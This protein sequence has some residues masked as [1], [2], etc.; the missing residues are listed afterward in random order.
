MAP[1]TL[2]HLL[3]LLCTLSVLS[4]LFS[5]LSLTYA[6]PNFR[7]TP[8]TTSNPIPTST[9]P[10]P[11]PTFPTPSPTPTP[12]I[13]RDLGSEIDSWIY[14]V[15]SEF[16]SEANDIVSE[17]NARLVGGNIPSINSPA[18]TTT[19]TATTN[20]TVPSREPASLLPPSTFLTSSIS[21]STNQ[22]TP[23]LL[24]AST[25]TLSPRHA[26]VLPTFRNHAVTKAVEISNGSA[27]ATGASTGG[28]VA[29]GKEVL[30]LC[31]VVGIA[32]AVVMVVVF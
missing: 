11:T 21:T 10:R 13:R 27:A 5:L 30:G 19:T 2:P 29:E 7:L 1:A 28:G 16:V 6:G 24:L 12:I 26:L 9:S 18:T 8:A 23:P 31:A 17:A 22:L 15:A 4:I 3:P 14:T 25:P 32:V 20:S